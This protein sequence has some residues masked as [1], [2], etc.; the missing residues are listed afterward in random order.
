[1]KIEI[2]EAAD[3][4]KLAAQGL[5]TVVDPLVFRCGELF[6]K[7]ANAAKSPDAVWELLNVNLHAIGMFFDALILNEKLPV[8]NYGDTFDMNLNFDQHVLTRINDYEEV[9][10]DVDVG[11]QAYMDVKNAALTEL[12]KVFTGERKIPAGTVEQI[13][14][15]V[16]VAEYQWSPS[17]GES[18]EARLNTYEEKLLADYILGGLI[19]GGYAQQMESEQLIQP[20]RSRLFLAISMQS[21]SAG[22]DVENELFDELKNRTNSAV[23]D[24][25]WRPTFFPYLLSK[26]EKP[27]ELLKEVVKLRRSP[28]VRDY[29]QWLGVVMPELKR[30][31]KITSETRRDVEKIVESVD[32]RLGA[33]STMPKVEIK[34][35]VAL[36]FPVEV[37]MMP[38]VK[39]LWGWFLNSLPGKSYRK[40]LTRAIVADHEYV[41]LENR[42]KTV[43]KAG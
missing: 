23:E 9:L 12:E 22:R 1:M 36:A 35:K 10:H 20:K 41:K 11:W 2:S 39:G 26:A 32:R 24:L 40:L 37:D 18:L 29:R 15:E 19:F 28:E 14:R 43:W 6:L 33:I 13:F 38:T 25:P 5:G 34:L 3:W 4:K 30:D 16:S 7:G 31:G 27:D 42:I 21:P 17:L 8:F